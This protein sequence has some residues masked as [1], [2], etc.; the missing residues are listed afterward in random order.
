LDKHKD[1]WQRFSKSGKVTDYIEFRRSILSETSA[2]MDEPEDM[3]NEY[4]PEHRWTG[5]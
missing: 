3:E 4:E 2:D 5:D 1:Y